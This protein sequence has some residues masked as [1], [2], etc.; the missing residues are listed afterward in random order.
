M[1]QCVF[2]WFYMFSS[3][4]T[5]VMALKAKEILVYDSEGPF[6]TFVEVN[7]YNC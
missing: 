1:L 2:W 6:R 5:V 7:Y 3:Q 4:V